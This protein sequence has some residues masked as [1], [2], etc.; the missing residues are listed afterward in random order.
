MCCD[1]VVKVFIK[2]DVSTS[3]GP[4]SNVYSHTDCGWMSRCVFDMNTHYRIFTAHTLWSKAD[5]ID[6]VFKQFFHRCSTLVFV[7][8]SKRSHKSFL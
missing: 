1:C 6:T 2:N 4:A 5:C 7:V 3:V 8:A